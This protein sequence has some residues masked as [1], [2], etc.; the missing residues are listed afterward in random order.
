M[1]PGKEPDTS[2]EGLLAREDAGDR[3]AW[4]IVTLVI[5]VLLSL[6]FDRLGLFFRIGGVLLLSCPVSLAYG[7]S[8][9]QSGYEVRG[10]AMIRRAW[11]PI[12]AFCLLAAILWVQ[13][14]FSLSFDQRPIPSRYHLTERVAP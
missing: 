2:Y 5:G 4:I 10:R 11:R 13:N 12:A 3:G 7:F 1:R 8:L 9:V 14:Q 6:W